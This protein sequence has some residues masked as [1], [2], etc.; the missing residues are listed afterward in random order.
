MFKA[1]KL[2]ITGKNFINFNLS[3]KIL[4]LVK[5]CFFFVKACTENNKLR[6]SLH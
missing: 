6:T 1:I 5:L 2:I 4:I 3:K